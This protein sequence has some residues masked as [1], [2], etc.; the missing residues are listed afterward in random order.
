MYFTKKI[1]NTVVHVKNRAVEGFSLREMTSDFLFMDSADPVATGE[2][3]RYGQNFR[4]G[5]RRGFEDTMV[6][7]HVACA[8]GTRGLFLCGLAVTC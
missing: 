6:S 1:I 3:L 4:L 5:I 8:L 7:C 2:V